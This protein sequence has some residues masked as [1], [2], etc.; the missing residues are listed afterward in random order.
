LE[1]VEVLLL[2]VELEEIREV[3]VRHLDL[4]PLVEEVETL[5]ETG[6]KLKMTE[7]LVAAEVV[8]QFGEIDFHLGTGL[9]VKVIMVLALLREVMLLL[10]EVEGLET[11][12]IQVEMT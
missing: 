3:I 6:A 7:A 10:V 1:V 4:Q 2:E 11:V 5:T 9:L 12:V 8:I